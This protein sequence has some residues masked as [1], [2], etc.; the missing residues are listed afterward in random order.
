EPS[1]GAMQAGV[2]QGT[3]DTRIEPY[4]LARAEAVSAFEREYLS[5]LIAECE[6]NASAAARRAEMDRAYL[7]SLLRRHGLR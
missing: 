7:L 3:D 6:G 5:R 4:K 2:A 1:A